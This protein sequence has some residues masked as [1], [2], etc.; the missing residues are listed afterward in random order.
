MIVGKITPAKVLE[1]HVRHI[2]SMIA[3]YETLGMKKYVRE[4]QKKLDGETMEE[5][6]FYTTTMIEAIRPLIGDKKTDKY[7]EEVRKCLVQKN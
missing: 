5:A 3:C 1:C 4:Y 7:I 6:V 2:K